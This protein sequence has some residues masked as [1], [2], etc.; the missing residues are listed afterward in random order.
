MKSEAE[1]KKQ[2]E[3]VYL[4]RLN[5]RLD[6]KLKRN[7]RNCSHQRETVFDLGDFGRLANIGCDLGQ[8]FSKNCDFHC[9]YSHDCVEEEFLSDIANP[10]ICGAKEPK[11]ATL[12]WVLHDGEGDL[13]N[14][15]AD[16]L[17]GGSVGKRGFFR[18]IWEVV[19]GK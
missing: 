9:V 12:M 4:H 13:P 14:G 1:I 11:I 3:E 10:S 19:C 17:G 7:C 8:V 6:R 2:L 5:L 15:D 16:K 18:R